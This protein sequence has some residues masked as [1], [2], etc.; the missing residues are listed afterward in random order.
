MASNSDYLASLQD[1]VKS[2][3]TARETVGDH[4]TKEI[5]TRSEEH[6]SELQSH[7]DLVCRPLLEKKKHIQ[8][9]IN[10]CTSIQYSLQTLH[11]VT[12]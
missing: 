11:P 1:N 2:D 5:N 6:T 9:H 8:L 10:A 4:A 3:A 12:T 7:S